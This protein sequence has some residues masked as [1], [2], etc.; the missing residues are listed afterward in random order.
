MKNK[1]KITVELQEK[2]GEIFK[3][4]SIKTVKKL[5]GTGY[6]S[7]PVGLIGK[8]VMISYEQEEGK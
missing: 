3:Y 5:S 2:D 1:P 4:S 6:V 8:E 7:L